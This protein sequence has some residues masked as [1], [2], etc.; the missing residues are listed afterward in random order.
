MDL[1]RVITGEDGV[2]SE[3]TVAKTEVAKKPAQTV[4]PADEPSAEWGWH[5]G[6]PNGTQIAGWISVIAL[7]GM[8]FGNQQGI[9]SGGG[10]LV[11]S[12]IW[13][14]ALAAV[15]AIGL[16]VDLSRRR[17]SWRR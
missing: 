17:K 4:D 5:G 11:E 2:V 16:L 12:D 3:A 14:I 8:L 6:F 1:A 10:Q 7:L 15:V 13:L 9:L